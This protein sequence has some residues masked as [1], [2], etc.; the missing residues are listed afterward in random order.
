MWKVRAKKEGSGGKVRTKLEEWGQ[1]EGKG[2]EK[3]G[4]GGGKWGYGNKWGY[5]GLQ[6]LIWHKTTPLR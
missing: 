6:S 5:T 2:E 1:S 4:K 3:L